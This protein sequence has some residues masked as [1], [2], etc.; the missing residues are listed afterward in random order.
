MTSLPARRCGGDG[1]PTEAGVPQHLRGEGLGG[2][3]EGEEQ[4]LRAD[5]RPARSPRL[6]PGVP[7]HHP[8]A[9]GEA[10]VQGAIAL[11]TAGAID[12]A[13]SIV[14]VQVDEASLHGLSP[15]EFRDL[16]VAIQ[17]LRGVRT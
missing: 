5:G 15:E 8:G 7:R 13:V 12:R 10:F 4:V 11:S 1:I 6:V 17:L 2:L 3:E 14:K 16:A 9:R